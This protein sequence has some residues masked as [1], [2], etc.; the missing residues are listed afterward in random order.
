MDENATGDDVRA[1]ALSERDRAVL[2]FEQRAPAAP[3]AREAAIRRD[4]GLG[5][6]RYQ[7]LLNSLIDRPDALAYAPMLV[8]RLQR[9]RAAR[10]DARATRSFGPTH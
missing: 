2:D 5:V 8:G 10:H 4:L 3:G 9:L 1:S 7:Q 6:I